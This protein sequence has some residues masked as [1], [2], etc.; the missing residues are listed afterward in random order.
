MT[1]AANQ[2]Y[3][4]PYF[5]YWQLIAAADTFLV[6]D[7]YAFMKGSW[8]PRNRILVGGMPQYFRIELDHQSCHRPVDVT[9]TGVDTV[10]G[11]LFVVDALDGTTTEVGE[12]TVVTVLPNEYGRYFLTHSTSLGEMGDDATPGIVIIARGGMLTVSAP[13]A[14]GRVRVVSVSGAT[15]FDTDGCSTTVQ[16]PLQQGIYV[17]EA[18][19]AAGHTTQKIVVR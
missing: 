6:S 12:G 4:L 7:D 15:V 14:L 18:D 1:L 5:P 19:G 2:P 10:D 13:Q 8:I 3:F 17:L 9:L 16:Q 11:S